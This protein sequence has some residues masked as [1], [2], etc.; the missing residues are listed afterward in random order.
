MIVKK[1]TETGYQY[2][3]DKKFCATPEATENI[4]NRFSEFMVSKMLK[5]KTA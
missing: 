4:V 1:V 2:K 5:R 3:V